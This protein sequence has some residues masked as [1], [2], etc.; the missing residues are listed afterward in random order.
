MSASKRF[1]VFGGSRYYPEG[2]AYDLLES[3]DT[4]AEAKAFA[5]GFIDGERSLAWVHVFDSSCESSV[6][7]VYCKEC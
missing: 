3:F 4:I 2:G 5:D 6:P 7:I 1:L